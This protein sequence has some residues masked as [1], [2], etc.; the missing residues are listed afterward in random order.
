MRGSAVLIDMHDWFLTHY[1]LLS[2]AANK[3][4]VNAAISMMVRMLSTVGD[5]YYYF[6]TTSEVREHARILC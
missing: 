4:V 2:L 6:N 3:W 1:K 5:H